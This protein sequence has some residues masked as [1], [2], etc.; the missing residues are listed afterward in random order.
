MKT[1]DFNYSL[2]DELIAQTP[3]EPRSSSRLLMLDRLQGDI[4]DT[5]FPNLVNQLDPGDLLVVNDTEVIPARIF[6]QKPSGGRVEVLLERIL[7]PTQI[8]ATTGSNKPLKKGQRIIID[9]QLGWFEVLARQS[10]FATL[11]WKGEGEV[12]SLFEQHGHI[13]LP[14]YISRDDNQQDKSRYQ[15]VYAECPGAVAAPTAG[16][17]FTDEF[18]DQIQQNGVEIAKL[19]LHVG[20]GTFQPVRVDDIEQ[21]VM[22]Y[23][24]VE[25]NQSLCDQI[26][27]TRARG[28]RVIAVGTT[29]VRA[30]ETMAANSDSANALRAF[31]GETNLFISPGYRLQLID[32]LLT[33]FHLPG[34]TLLMLVSAFANTSTVMQAYQ[35]AVTERY[36]FF[37]YGDAMFIAD[38]HK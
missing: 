9:A 1:S 4:V 3:I 10:S 22:H 20:A 30:L 19:T 24:L 17:H 26:V 27:A 28:N 38:I 2:P 12:L 13:P 31:N 37:S 18:L 25:V 33:N 32:G 35:H 6:G 29:V 5:E 16:L 7:S 23:E 11:D 34:S 15:T 8:L 21:H 36:R 14:P